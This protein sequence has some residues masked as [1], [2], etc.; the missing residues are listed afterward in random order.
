MT[1]N[2]FLDWVEKVITELA[3]IGEWLNTPLITLGNLTFTPLLLVTV[4]GLTAF[5]VIAVVKWGLS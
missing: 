1:Y 3:K 4:G 2:G 5:V